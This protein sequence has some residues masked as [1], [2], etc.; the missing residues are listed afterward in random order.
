MKTKIRLT[1]RHK[2]LRKLK[3][4]LSF[5]ETRLVKAMSNYQ[6]VIHESVSSEQKSQEMI[7]LYV[8]IDDLKKEIDELE[9]V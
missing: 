5:Y 3:E 8:T 1:P 7:M 2:H 4:N 9:D 6:G